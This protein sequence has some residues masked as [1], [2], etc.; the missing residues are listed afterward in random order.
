MPNNILVYLTNIFN[1]NAYFFDVRTHQKKTISESFD[2]DFSEA[3][4]FALKAQKHTYSLINSTNFF[5]INILLHDGKLIMLVPSFTLA[6]YV[7]NDFNRLFMLS[8][9]KIICQ[10]VYEI[11]TSTSAPTDEIHIC[12]LNSQP[13]ELI[14]DS[15]DV[16][17]LSLND[18]NIKISLSILR[19]D[20]QQ[21]LF[22][23]TKLL[24]NKFILSELDS[25]FASNM[26]IEYVSLLSLLLINYGYPSKDIY[27][28]K[29]KIYNIIDHIKIQKV[30]IKLL[31][32]ILCIYFNL[33]LDEKHNPNQP[34]SQKIKN[35]I[36]RNI[37]RPL[38]LVDISLNL[39]TPLKH[40]NPA[41]KS[42]YDLTI[43]QYIRRRK[44]LISK[45]LLIGT[46][47][48]LQDIA[49]LVGFNSQSYF[50]STFKKLVGQTPS[51]YRNN[52]KK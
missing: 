41:F 37:T 34:L 24:K 2:L 5:T 28:I 10:L 33:L 19:H 18:L 44:I 48:T 21:F 45:N 12:S 27:S 1:L 47:L 16:D 3:K 49:N 14:D 38:N 6:N 25:K 50:V 26:L 30:N 11:Y 23:K 4:D 52:F 20:N 46:Q 13:P 32:Q 40:L 35:Y 29:N 51:E 7:Q 15:L 9:L 17:M 8:R 39:Y 43:N 31:D 36:D 42:Q 22:W